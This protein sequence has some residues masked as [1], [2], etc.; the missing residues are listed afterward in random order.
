M[1]QVEKKNGD[2]EICHLSGPTPPGMMVDLE[3][4][5]GAL[6]VSLLDHLEGQVNSLSI[7][8]IWPPFSLQ[9]S[10]AKKFQDTQLLILRTVFP[11]TQECIKGA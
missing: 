5:L 9:L 8:L 10:Q 11:T 2:P 6:N 7:S 1:L 3:F 4:E